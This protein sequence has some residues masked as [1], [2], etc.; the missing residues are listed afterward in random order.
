MDELNYRVEIF[1]QSNDGL[2]ER[3]SDIPRKKSVGFKETVERIEPTTFKSLDDIS[4][5]G[6]TGWDEHMTR[7][8]GK[9]HDVGMQAMPK[10]SALRSPSPMQVTGLNEREHESSY[11]RYLSP[12]S[13]KTSP[14]GDIYA[15]R[16]DPSQVR[17][18]AVK[19][20]GL[21]ASNSLDDDPHLNEE[22][23]RLATSVDPA[24]VIPEPDYEGYSGY[25]PAQ[26][27]PQQLAA[28]KPPAPQPPA[29]HPKKKDASIGLTNRLLSNAKN[30]LKRVGF[31]RASQTTPN[32]ER[33]DVHD[34][35][36]QASRPSP[37]TSKATLVKSHAPPPPPPPVPPAAFPPAP[38][39][40]PPPTSASNVGSSRSDLQMRLGSPITSP[41]PPPLAG[42]NEMIL[43][44][45][46]RQAAV[47]RNYD[48]LEKRGFKQAFQDGKDDFEL[49]MNTSMN[50]AMAS[51]MTED[52]KIASVV[53]EY[54]SEPRHKQPPK[55]NR[56]VDMTDV[57]SE[58]KVKSKQRT[59]R[60]ISVHSETPS[61]HAN[62]Y[63]KDH[64]SRIQ[65]GPASNV[66]SG[67]GT[68]KSSLDISPSKATPDMRESRIS[69][70]QARS[71]A[72]IDMDS[73]DSSLTGLASNPVTPRNAQLVNAPDGNDGAFLEMEGTLKEFD[74]VIRSL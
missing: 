28:S 48:E 42:L 43:N 37:P 41:S 5:I 8:E 56:L 67:H 58:L 53:A 1:Q 40:A 13:D 50:A 3:K 66:M 16:G 61:M 26:S 73:L 69:R 31:R 18:A 15:G 19:G 51:E 57:L 14:Q 71:V 29:A 70:R 45:P 49:E 72:D 9:R 4:M 6:K 63:S 38:P 22:M 32:N 10:K 68:G 55:V 64:G 54:G 17:S 23:D 12:D 35:H 46:V 25:V 60:P 2:Q 21:V 44:S 7:Y 74:D 62:S 11:Q 52:V 20:R 30:K 39:P 36:S 65:T 24:F 33:Q 47:A 59:K 34:K 27:L